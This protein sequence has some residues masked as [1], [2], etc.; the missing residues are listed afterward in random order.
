MALLFDSGLTK[1]LGSELEREWAGHLLEAVFFDTESRRVRLVFGNVTWAWFL[2]PRHG[3]L[4]HIPTIPTARRRRDRGVLAGPRR[5]ERVEVEPD[6]R[7]LCLVLHTQSDEAEERLVFELATS[8]WNAVHVAGHV[9][10]VLHRRPGATAL[11]PGAEWNPST[12]PRMWADSL[13]DP[14]A[15]RALFSTGAQ[16]VTDLARKIAYMS[17]INEAFVFADG[18]AADAIEA[19]ERYERLRTAIVANPPEAW[20]LPMRAGWQPYPSS[21][22]RPDA[23]RMGSLLDAFA[24]CTERD[25]DLH[26]AVEAAG[27]DPEIADLREALQSRHKRAARKLRAL[28]T[29]LTA[30]AEA[31]ALRELGH[32][33]LAHKASVPSGATEVHLEDFAGCPITIRLDPTLNAVGNAEAYYGRARRL[34]RAARELPPRVAHAKTIVD[35]LE[36]ALTSL[37]ESGS[38]PDLRAL[39]GSRVARPARGSAGRSPASERLPY[40]VYR[41]TGGLEIRAGRT[42]RDND[43]L[44][45]GHSSPE[46]I[47]MHVRE[48]PGSHVVLRWTRRD[49]NPPHRDITE[50]A[51]VAAVLSQ[52]RGSGLVP[53]S[54]TRRKYVRKPRKAGPGTV[55]TQRT[56]T[57]F[58]EPDALLVDRLAVDADR[59]IAG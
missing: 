14:T 51:I 37:R 28:E 54:W 58:V 3:V 45:F 40:R 23:E 43:A 41:T 22:E 57:M 30:G 10:A 42:A 7:R 12:S 26:D 31:P 8:R 19:Y 20:L 24:R 1:A 5:V 18:S 21:L 16:P 53:V 59:P 34:G 55:T 35:E 56:Q 4:I 52:A 47:W 25:H 15:W 39:A 50:A 48:A 17:G 32:L 44:T 2:H 11:R 9:R 38:S 27:E 49:Q 13:P 36:Q 46:D 6:T 33:L 29:Q